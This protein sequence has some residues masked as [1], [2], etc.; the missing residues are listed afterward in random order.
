MAQLTRE[1]LCA[2]KEEAIAAFPIQGKVLA[3]DLYGSGHINDTFLLVTEQGGEGRRYILQRINHFVFPRPDEIMENILGVTTHLREKITLRGGDPDRETLT[4]LKTKEGAAFYR[5]SIG[6]YWRVYLFIEDNLSLDRVETPEQFY[7]SALAFG[8]FQRDL[9]DFPAEKLHEAIRDFH[10]TPVRYQ[11]LMKAAEA[12]KCGRRASVAAE[13]AFAEGQKNF[14]ETLYHAYRAGDLPLRVTHN[15]TKLNN[16]LFDAETSAPLAV[17][18]LDTV[19]PGFSVNDFGDSIRFGAST[20]GESETDLSK[21][22]V[23]LELYRIYVKGFLEGCEGRLTEAEVKLLPVGAKMMTLECGLRFLTDY[24]EG[25]V[26]FRTHYEGHNL[27]RARN[28]FR[29]VA[30][31][32]RLW[33]EMQIK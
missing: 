23:D 10:N 17:I 19:M 27:D 32:D 5:D 14:T 16:I 29:L 18:D 8:R 33:E 30:E 15:D 21:V 28:Q 4:V 12:D 31:M 7:Q 11:N 3:C 9:S 2:K 22:T 25:D 1:E 26:Y 24:L 13:L 6:S 20:A